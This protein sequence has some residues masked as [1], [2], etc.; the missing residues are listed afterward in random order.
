MI[1]N[2]HLRFQCIVYDE[3]ANLDVPPLVYV[4]NLSRNGTYI[5]SVR[6]CFDHSET[7]SGRLIG[8]NSSA[9]L[10]NDGDELWIN[11]VI[12]IKYHSLAKQEGW[13]ET[14]KVQQLEKR[15]FET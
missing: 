6:D 4:Q 5:R 2:K 9:V 1:S 3:D 7:F 13:T 8:S 10:L 15:V 14:D 11:P 12:Y